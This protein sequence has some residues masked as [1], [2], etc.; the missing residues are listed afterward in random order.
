MLAALQA[1]PLDWNSE[2][3]RRRPTLE[4]GLQ[5]WNLFDQERIFRRSMLLMHSRDLGNQLFLWDGTELS[6]AI[7]HCRKAIH[8][9]FHPIEERV[10]E[11]CN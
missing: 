2:Y 3:L 5:R 1:I 7:Q 4:D 10:V 6:D 8:P 11:V 9:Q